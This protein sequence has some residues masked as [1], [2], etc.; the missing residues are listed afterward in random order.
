[1]LFITCGPS[2]AV[3]PPVA[4][5]GGALSQAETLYGSLLAGEDYQT[6]FDKAKVVSAA[7]QPLP[8]G[9]QPVFRVLPSHVRVGRPSV[10]ARL[11]MCCLFLA[12]TV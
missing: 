6:A 10:V 12:P 2:F 7:K 5:G 3:R 8:A 9:C 1:L 4:V 11:L